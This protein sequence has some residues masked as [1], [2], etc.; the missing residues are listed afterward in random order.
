MRWE[1]SRQAS[2]E[3]DD[4]I[5]Y[6]DL[7]FGIEQTENYVGGLY[8]AF[9]LLSD[10]PKMGQAWA[11]ERR[12]LIYRSHYVFYRILD[13]HI[14]ITDIMNTRMKIPAEWKA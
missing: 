6:T 10:N 11:G 13:D 8:N 5:R 3:I 7:N 4:I 14:F 2:A 1:L 12:C 9:D